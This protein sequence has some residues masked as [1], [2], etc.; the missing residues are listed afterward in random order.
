MEQMT[1]DDIKQCT[2]PSNECL[3]CDKFEE[4]YKEKENETRAS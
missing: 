4:C 3:G 2:L 1:I